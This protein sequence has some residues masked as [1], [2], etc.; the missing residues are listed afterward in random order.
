MVVAPAF[1]RRPDRMIVPDHVALGFVE[2]ASK[3]AMRAYLSGLVGSDRVPVRKDFESD[4][5]D[6]LEKADELI[7]AI[8]GIVDTLADMIRNRPRQT[9]LTPSADGSTLEIK[10]GPQTQTTSAGSPRTSKTGKKKTNGKK[11]TSKKATSKKKGK[12]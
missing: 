12:A 5:P 8:G 3:G 7:D 9:K 1:Q 6:D 4:D 2:Y 10:T 11:A